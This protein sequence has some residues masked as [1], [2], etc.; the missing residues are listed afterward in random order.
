MLSGS[1]ITGDRLDLTDLCGKVIVLNAWG[2]WC[3]PYRAEAPDLKKASEETLPAAAS[4]GGAMRRFTW[5]RLHARAVMG[6]GGVLLVAVGV[7]PV[8]GWCGQLIARLQMLIT[9]FQLPL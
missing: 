7:M 5:A 1:T 3:A 8:A 2:S 4:F 9:G 6:F